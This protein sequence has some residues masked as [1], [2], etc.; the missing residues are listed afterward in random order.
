MLH[1]GLKGWILSN[2]HSIPLVTVLTYNKM[3]G[4]RTLTVEEVGLEAVPNQKAQ[5]MTLNT[6]PAQGAF[7]F[8]QCYLPQMSL[9]QGQRDEGAW[10]RGGGGDGTG[11]ATQ[12]SI[13]SHFC[14]GQRS[15]NNITECPPSTL[16]C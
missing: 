9:P 10:G 2:A 5:K 4:E 8:K 11:G 1:S 6:K 14:A 16:V 13:L 3:K 15:P 7:S 12:G